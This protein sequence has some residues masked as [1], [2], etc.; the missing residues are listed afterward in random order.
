MPLKTYDESID[1]L[2]NSLDSAKLGDSDKLDGFKRLDR[3]TR[4]WK[5][6]SPKA[7]FEAIV[8]HEHAISPSLDGRSVFDDR[9]RK[10]PRLKHS[11]LSLFE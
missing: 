1:I 5:K 11:Q 10:P 7:D 3:F 8:A 6:V 4:A 2:R 9:K